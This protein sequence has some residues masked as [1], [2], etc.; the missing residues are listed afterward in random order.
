MSY[1]WNLEKIDYRFLFQGILPYLASD[2]KSIL[3]KKQILE[4]NNSYSD[5]VWN[6]P[7]MRTQSSNDL[8]K[9]YTEIKEM[10]GVE[11]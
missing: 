6:W 3:E 4:W 10:A 7:V 5:W 9:L 1:K 8:W 2:Q 11:L